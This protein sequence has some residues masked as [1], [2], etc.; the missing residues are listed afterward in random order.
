MMNYTDRHACFFMRL[1]SKDILL[2][3]EMIT[4]AALYYGRRN[5]L[6]DYDTSQAHLA[7]QVGGSEPTLLAQAAKMGE[8][9]GFDEVNLNVGCPSPRVV[10]GRFGACLML[11]PNLVADCVKAMQDGVTI[12]ITVKCRIGVDHYDSYSLLQRFIETLVRAGC[13]TFIIHARKAWLS[14][15]SPKENREIPPLC[16][17]TVRKI[18]QDFPSCTIILNGGLKSI[19]QIAAE[20]HGIDGMMI[21][22]AAFTNPYL[23][24]EIQ[25]KYFGGMVHSRAEI[26]SQYIPYVRN[27]LA[28]GVNFSLLIR[29]LLG[30]FHE[31][32]N[33]AN[34]RRYLSEN[35]HRPCSNVELFE[36]ALRLVS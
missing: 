15:L 6:L 21:G 34:F 29:P 17:T 31:Q 18:K 32:K 30:L 20:N 24:A 22:R 3:T 7:L 28:Q 11:E 27:Q 8:A 23:L 12:P 26:V 36:Q 33:G 1:I 19:T 5:V 2:Y 25:S 16:Y 14:G 10:S 35:V 9:A 13:R 4:A